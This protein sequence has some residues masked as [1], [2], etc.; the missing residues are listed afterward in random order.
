[1]NFFYTLVFLVTFLIVNSNYE[2]VYNTTNLLK[3]TEDMRV[4]YKSYIADPV[5]FLYNNSFSHNTK[6]M[7]SKT[8]NDKYN[9]TRFNLFEIDTFFMNYGTRYK[10]FIT[11]YDSLNDEN[12]F[13][14]YFANTITLNYSDP[15]S[16][17]NL[18]KNSQFNKG[19]ELGEIN[20]LD[21]VFML[22]NNITNY[23]T[24]NLV[25]TRIKYMTD[26][27]YFKIQNEVI[28]I[29]EPI[30]EYLYIMYHD[31]TVGIFNE[32]GSQYVIKIIF[33]VVIFLFNLQYYYFNVYVKQLKKLVYNKAII[34]LIPVKAF[35][36]KEIEFHDY[37]RVVR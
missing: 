9:A 32:I 6:D 28:N 27:I 16:A 7:S 18:C 31:L 15:V 26:P 33:L 8:L 22:L 2:Y 14:N 12:N 4:K 19:F 35:K 5:Q 13:C 24:A 25:N 11:A 21:F 29:F 20:T 37:L 23:K 34:L 36:G 1:M 17:M 10:T 3:I 30:S